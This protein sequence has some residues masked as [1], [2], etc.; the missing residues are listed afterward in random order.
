M[1]DKIAIVTGATGQDG[2]YLC[3]LLIDKGYKEVRCAVRRTSRCLSTSNIKHIID[4]LKI[5]ECDITDYT[6]VIKLFSNSDGPFEVYNLAAQSQVGTSFTC[7]Q[8]TVDIN[9][10]GTLNILDVIVKLGIVDKC[11]YYQAST[12]EMYGKVQDIPQTEKTV[13][14]PRSPY[15]IAKLAAHWFTINYRETYNLFACSGILFNHE[16]PRRGK[17][18]I[19]QKIV[20]G[21]EDI[22]NNKIDFI[23]L[24]NLNAKRD[25]GHAKDY[26]YAMWLM[27]QQ[28]NPDDYVVASGKQYSVRDFVEKVAGY[29]GITITWEG[30]GV[31]EVGRCCKTNKILVKVSEKFYRPC[32]VDTLVG[33]STKIRAIGWKPN[34]NLDE[35]IKD[36][37][38]NY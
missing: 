7:P 13:F 25:W 24:G 21:F 30:E 11:K 12:S 37:I 33:D 17:Y 18:F 8:T 32:E 9:T 28:Q 2:S 3:E 1:T 31:S 38:D 26:V 5:Y 14:Y 23:E 35:L 10:M 22:N 6:S 34:F 15:G 4:K 19:T 20:K 36:M 27:L 16:S 29:H